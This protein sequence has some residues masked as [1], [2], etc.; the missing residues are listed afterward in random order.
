MWSDYFKE[1]KKGY[2]TLCTQHLSITLKSSKVIS[3]LLLPFE[4]HPTSLVTLDASIIE[5][6]SCDSTITSS[7]IHPAQTCA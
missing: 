1:L 6:Q 5:S 7:G 3:V 4:E 2:E